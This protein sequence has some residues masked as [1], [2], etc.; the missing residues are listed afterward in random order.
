VYLTLDLSENEDVAGCRYL[1]SWVYIADENH[2]AIEPN[3][4]PGANGT[5][6]LSGSTAAAEPRRD[7]L[8]RGNP[9]LAVDLL[10]VRVS[11]AWTV[12]CATPIPQGVK[13]ECRYDF[14]VTP[15][16]LNRIPGAVFNCTYKAPYVRK[17]DRVR[18]DLDDYLGRAEVFTFY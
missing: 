3:D 5:V 14:R 2:I 16:G 10:A 15:K 9:V 13:H 11:L 18:V 4:T 17:L 12:A 7:R 1:G 8:A 6:N